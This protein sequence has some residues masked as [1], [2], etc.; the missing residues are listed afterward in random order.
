MRILICDDDD[1]VEI[2][3]TRMIEKFKFEKLRKEQLEEK[4]NR[5]DGIHEGHDGEDP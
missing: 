2:K 5:V 3:R 1:V 4:G